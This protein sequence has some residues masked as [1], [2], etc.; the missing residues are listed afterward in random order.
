MLGTLRQDARPGPERRDRG[1]PQV[2][3]R[4]DGGGPCRHHE[5]PGSRDAS[6][7][8]PLRAPIRYPGGFDAGER[9]TSGVLPSTRGA[10][11]LCTSLWIAWGRLGV[12]LWIV[13]DGAGDFSGFAA[14][15]QR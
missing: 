7:A 14:A 5:A 15:G 9:R 4:I 8:F 13:G 6:L 3:H 12:L 2:I 11:V 10:S 1:R